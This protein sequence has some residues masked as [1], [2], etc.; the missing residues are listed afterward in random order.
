MKFKLLPVA[1]MALLAGCQTNPMQSNSGVQMVNSNTSAHLQTQLTMADYVRLASAVTDKMLSSRM[2]RNW[3][4]KRPRLI[5][6]KL[7]NNTDNENL[8]MSDI[9]DRISEDLLNS[10]TVRLV[11]KSA[12]SFDYVVRSE[13][14]SNRQYGNDNKELVSYA[15]QLKLFNIDGE[16]LGQWSGTLTLA[17]GVAV[18]N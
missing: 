6:A 14:T 4:S 18:I 17:K 1:A 11:H 9:Y 13:L 10:G 8:R 15:L 5:V 16:M 7:V 2:V 3:G 12:T